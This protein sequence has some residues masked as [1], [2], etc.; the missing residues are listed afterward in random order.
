MKGRKVKPMKVV[1]ASGLILSFLR[2]KRRIELMCL[3]GTF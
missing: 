3:N 2:S 1:S